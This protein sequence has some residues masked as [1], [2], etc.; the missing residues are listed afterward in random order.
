M[1]VRVLL[2]MFVLVLVV[3]EWSEARG[4]DCIGKGY[5]CKQGRACCYSEDNECLQNVDFESPVTTWK[6]QRKYKTIK[7]CMSKQQ[8]DLKQRLKFEVGAKKYNDDRE[9][10]L[11]QIE[12]GEGCRVPNCFTSIEM[13]ETK[14]ETR[15]SSYTK[16][17]LGYTFHEQYKGFGCNLI[18]EKV[19]CDDTEKKMKEE[20]LNQ[21]RKEIKIDGRELYNCNVVVSEVRGKDDKKKFVP[22]LKE[23][24]I[25]K[26]KK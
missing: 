24:C 21:L 22:I 4:A 2:T 25:L 1:L 18:Q 6:Q 19:A 11:E 23:K 13:K 17:D 12:E 5:K 15:F 7:W 3:V 8:Y 14:V 9:R 20:Y 16:M 26:E 10:Y